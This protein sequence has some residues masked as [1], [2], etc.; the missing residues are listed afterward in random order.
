VCE[1]YLGEIRLFAFDFPPRGWARCA[2]QLLSIS[3]NQA[4]F[5]LLGTQYGGDGR[6]TFALPDL[7]DRGPAHVDSTNGTNTIGQQG[8]EATHTLTVNEMPAHTHIVSARSAPTTGDPT[9]A[10]WAVSSTAAYATNPN[11]AMASG[12][13]GTTGGGQP[14]ENMPPYLTMNFGIA[15]VGIFPSRN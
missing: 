2:G 13:S 12:S 15:L 7:R 4:L 3:Q 8:G 6:T 14:H 1:P 10:V 9:S 5:A 11:T